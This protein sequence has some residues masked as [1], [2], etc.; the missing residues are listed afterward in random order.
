MGD[1]IPYIL[2]VKS[3]LEGISE[4][5]VYC[6][7]LIPLIISQLKKRFYYV[8]DMEKNFQKSKFYILSTICHPM[9]KMRWV[10]EDEKNKFFE[11]FLDEIKKSSSNE[12][13][14]SDENQL[15]GDSF[16]TFIKKND[17]GKT[18]VSENMARKYLS[19][20]STDLNMLDNYPVIKDMFLKYNCGMLI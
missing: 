1:V 11:I 17:T 5:M 13:T 10:K 7:E 9:W 6:Q 15:D 18:D 3:R 16:F 8:F 12:N 14:K 2:N 4:N 20:I 19:N